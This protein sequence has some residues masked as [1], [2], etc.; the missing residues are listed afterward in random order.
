ML[1][2]QALPVVMSVSKLLLTDFFDLMPQIV[3]LLPPTTN[4][5]VLM[6]CTGE[7]INII[8]FSEKELVIRKLSK[9]CISV[10]VLWSQ[11]KL[12][13]HSKN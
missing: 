6:L 7:L 13:V 1:S 11:V 3:Y 8:D 2:S 4:V 12:Q 10:S 5:N 9:V